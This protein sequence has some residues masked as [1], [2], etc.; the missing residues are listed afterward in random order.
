M[1]RASQA[2]EEKLQV[3]DHTVRVCSVPAM[4]TVRPV[5]PRQV[6]VTAE[7]I[8]LAPTVRNVVTGTMETQPWAPPL[9]ANPVPVLA[10]QVVPLSRRQRRWC[11]PTVQRAL[12]ARDVNS[13]MTATLETLWAAVGP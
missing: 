5:T 9:T 1:R 10:A 11:A 3:L 7:T 13:V 4:D 2:T 6:S 12:P 8:Q